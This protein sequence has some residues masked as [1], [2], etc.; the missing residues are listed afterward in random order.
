MPQQ[1]VGTTRWYDVTPDSMLLIHRSTIWTQRSR[2]RGVAVLLV[3]SVQMLLSFLL[4]LLF[5]MKYAWTESEPNLN[6][7]C[8]EATLLVRSL[9]E[10]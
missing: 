8:F 5:T 9:S 1:P 2:L 10:A 3:R 6:C 4:F 7:P